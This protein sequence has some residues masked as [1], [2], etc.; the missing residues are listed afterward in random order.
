[1]LSGEKRGAP[2]KPG[3]AVD[4]SVCA[5]RLS[6]RR[7]DTG[8]GQGRQGQLHPVGRK[9]QVR[10]EASAQHL[11]PCK[12]TVKRVTRLSPT[13]PLA[14][15]KSYH[16]L[17]ARIGTTTMSNA[18]AVRVRIPSRRACAAVNRPR[19]L[20]APRDDWTT[21]A[22]DSRIRSRS[23]SPPTQINRRLHSPGRILDE[24]SVDDPSC[25]VAPVLSAARH[26]GAPR[27]SCGTSTDGRRT[28][29]SGLKAS[30]TEQLNELMA[31]RGR[32]H[33]NLYEVALW[34]DNA[35]RTARRGLFR[36]RYTTRQ[37]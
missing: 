33:D 28:T 9:G 10:V 35:A 5:S 11:T 30:S 20:P 27:P 8:P 26:P 2:R 16:R 24:T 12:S 25:R 21:Q 15:A 7:I 3:E 37:S 17:P 22:L 32:P 29:A 36:V 13:G 6:N 14:W 19:R 1:V 23:S 31:D 18:A 34:A 4:S